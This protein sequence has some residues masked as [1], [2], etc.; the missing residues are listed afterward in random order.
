MIAIFELMA[1]IDKL[2]KI[3]KEVGATVNKTQIVYLMSSR[4]KLSKEIS[5]LR[6]EISIKVTD[7]NA[8]GFRVFQ[9]VCRV[10]NSFYGRRV[11]ESL[12]LTFERQSGLS[13]LEITSYPEIFEEVVRNTLGLKA[14]E[15]VRGVLVSEIAREFGFRY[16]RKMPLSEAIHM[17]GQSGEIEKKNS[18]TPL[19]K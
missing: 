3:E 10:L 12:L 4:R 5:A 17:A 9:L 6:G 11:G 8:S 13:S 14:A 2:R 19:R 15:S 1:D 7:L 16:S 18:L